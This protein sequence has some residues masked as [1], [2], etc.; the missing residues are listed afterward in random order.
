MDRTLE[1][2]T[3]PKSDLRSKEDDDVI[4]LEEDKV[5]VLDED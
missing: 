3:G 4:T 5:T 1:T 2:F